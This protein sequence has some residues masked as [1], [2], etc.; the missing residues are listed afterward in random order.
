MA[1]RCFPVICE[2][3]DCIPEWDGIICWPQ[4]RAGQL[5]SV[6][7][8][9]Y[10]YDFNHRGERANTQMWSSSLVQM[11]GLRSFPPCHGLLCWCYHSVLTQ[12]EPT[13]SVTHLGAGSKC[14]ASTAHGP[15][16][17]SAPHT[18]PPTTG[19]K[20]RYV[21][22]STCVH[23]RCEFLQ[24]VECGV[25]VD[26]WRKNIQ[27]CNLLMWNYYNSH[28]MWRFLVTRVCCIWSHMNTLNHVFSEGV[29]EAS[30]H[31][32]CRLLHFTGIADGGSV[33]P[34]LFQVRNRK[35]QQYSTES[36]KRVF[37]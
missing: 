24:L 12:G 16:T 25:F 2:E 8:P 9:E 14:P 29:Q 18:W 19:A 10:I 15:T 28:T 26:P 4:S 6:L 7:C 37:F 11:C 3:G 32:H 36:V 23:R 21:C 5:V 22:L 17:P 27:C 31:V 30:S 33:H 1:N 20:R 13:A 34:L 35:H